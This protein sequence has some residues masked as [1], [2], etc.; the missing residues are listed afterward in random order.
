MNK[1]TI[2]MIAALAENRAIGK[3][4]KLLWHISE[5]FKRFKAI[6]S[7]HPII[8]GRKTYQ[9]IGKPLP[10]RS[11]IV[12]TR[13]TTF[14]AE[15]CIVVNSLEQ[16]IQ[17]AQEIDQEEIFIIGGGE[18]YRQGIQ[19]ADKLYLTIVH[20]EFD[21]DTFFPDYSAFNKVVFEQKSESN[22]YTYTF[23]DV[24]KD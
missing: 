1:P 11:N 9:S 6:T 16:G 14:T 21:G 12:V 7:G 15:G 18:L 3:D 24:I 22:G 19:Y 20:K 17:K 23:L 13:D 4:N 8:M 10:N 2:S 5:D